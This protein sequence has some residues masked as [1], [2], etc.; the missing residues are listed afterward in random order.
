MEEGGPRI[1]AQAF[2]TRPEDNLLG[3]S[4]GGGPFENEPLISQIGQLLR[5]RYPDAWVV[6]D[7]AVAVNLPTPDPAVGA[8]YTATW[9]MWEETTWQGRPDVRVVLYD[10]P[11]TPL[12]I[13]DRAGNA[14]LTIPNP[15]EG[16]AMQQA[17]RT[18]AAQPG[19]PATLVFLMPPNPITGAQLSVHP[20]APGR[21]GRA[22]QWMTTQAYD[23]GYPL[24]KIHFRPQAWAE[25]GR[26]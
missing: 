11:P 6:N 3:I 16:S 23:A 8:R 1:K 21:E 24:S 5:T 12:V 4:Y 19:G 25:T 22:I 15:F 26:R 13:R 7:P 20:L 14:V 9:P 17:F 18:L 2:S 10:P